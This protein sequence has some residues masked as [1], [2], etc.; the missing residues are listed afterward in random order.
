MTKKGDGTRV[1][2]PGLGDSFSDRADESTIREWIQ[3]NN[4]LQANHPLEEIE[5]F[6]EKWLRPDAV[7]ERSR[8]IYG[9]KL[10]NSSLI[11]RKIINASFEAQYMEGRELVVGELFAQLVRRYNSEEIISLAECLEAMEKR[12]P[13]N[14]NSAFWKT[15]AGKM[16]LILNSGLRE[17]RLISKQELREALVQ[18]G[19]DIA[20]NKLDALV[21]G[22][23]LNGLPASRQ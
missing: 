23:G 18:S 7:R 5:R 3:Q 20:Q 19:T 11:V 2:D 17:G 1:S 10:S 15:H 21:K 6:A 14:P 22:I 16:I 13:M 12:G 4:D 9:T 8:L